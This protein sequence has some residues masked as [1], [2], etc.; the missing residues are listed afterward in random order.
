MERLPRGS[1]RTASDTI[2]TPKYQHIMRKIFIAL[3]VALLGFS[4]S[5]QTPKSTKVVTDSLTFM[6][7]KV[8][9]FEGVSQNG[10]KKFWIELPTD[11]GVRKVH[12]SESHVTS[13]RLLALIERKD[14]Q[15]G[16]YSYSIKFAEP[17]KSQASGKADL[18]SLK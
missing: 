7:D 10:N 8:Q 15:T 5:A 3:I 2:L 16:K 1:S 6:P 11:A 9:I 4:A 18:S 14:E 12:L 13:K 17:K